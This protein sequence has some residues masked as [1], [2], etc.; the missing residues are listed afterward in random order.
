M[1]VPANIPE[2]D[3]RA[4]DEIGRRQGV[5]IS[6]VIRE[7]VRLYLA[8]RADRDR[9]LA[10]FVGLWGNGDIDGVEYQRR[11]RTKW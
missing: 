8:A 7:A 3:V 1:R 10:E 2:S 5:S 6:S 9:G 4:L 11:I